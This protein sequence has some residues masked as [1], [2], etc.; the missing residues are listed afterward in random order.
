M[1]KRRWMALFSAVICLFACTMTAFAAQEYTPPFELESGSV[2]LMNS[3]TGEIIYQKNGDQPVDPGFITQLMVAI[4][5]LENIDDL[6]T[7]ITYKVY[8]QDMLYGVS[9]ATTGGLVA[10][11]TVTADGLLYALT[12]QNACDAALILAD[13][14]GDGSLTHFVEMMNERAHELGATN[15]TFVN[16]TG[17]YEASGGNTTTA[18]D[19]AILARHALTLDGFLD[20]CE[21]RSMEIG[22]TNVHSSLVEINYNSISNTQSEYYYAAAQGIKTAGSQEGIGY[23]LVSTATQDGFTYLLVILDTPTADS[24]GA[25][26]TTYY[27]YTE[28]AALYDWVFDAFTVMTLVE[29]GTP[30]ADIPVRLSTQKDVCSVIAADRFT[31]LVPTETDVAGITLEPVLNQE[32]LDAPVTKGDTVGYARIMMGG[33][34]LGQVELVANEDIEQSRMLYY[35]S[36]VQSFFGSFWFKFFFIFLLILLGL[37]IALMVIRNRNHRRYGTGRRR[38]PRRRM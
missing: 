13:Y 18:E 15:T 19:V 28:T 38:R 34:E 33:E 3:E 11:E 23:G 9:G 14:M 29:E 30:V 4:M 2:C 31:A 20:Y 5:A 16:A 8:L 37:Y 7:E 6:S 1:L 27:H 24:S 21:A 35:W 12:L 25:D 26:L 32:Y 22:P 17:L 10:G 36:R